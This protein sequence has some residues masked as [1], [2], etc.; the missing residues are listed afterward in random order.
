M[1]V[2]VRGRVSVQACLCLGVREKTPG[3]KS[4]IQT[5]HGTERNM[6]SE[7]IMS[8]WVLRPPGLLLS[9][10]SLRGGETPKNSLGKNERVLLL[11]PSSSNS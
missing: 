2:L 11:P 9:F 3:S 10:S 8:P 5:R 6:R 1:C 7:F 4:R